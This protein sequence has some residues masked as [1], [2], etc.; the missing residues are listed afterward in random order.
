[1]RKNLSGDVVVGA[2]RA[3]LSPVEISCLNGAVWKNENIC[4][5]SVGENTLLLT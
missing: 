1:M 4:G 2:R 5:G 3:A